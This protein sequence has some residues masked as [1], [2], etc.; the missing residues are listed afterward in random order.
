MGNRHRATRLPAAMFALLWHA[1]SAW[2]ADAAS[3][4]EPIASTTEPAV[5]EAASADAAPGPPPA[6]EQPDPHYGRAAL[7]ELG[8]LA[9]GTGWYWAYRGE[10]ANDWD[11]PDL[12][13][14]VSGEAWRL[15]N[16]GIAMNFLAHALSGS[17][18][19]AVARANELSLWPSAGY[20]F[21]TSFAWE[22]LIEFREK[23]S[24]N[25]VLVTP[26]AGIAIGEY[27]H[28]LALYVNSSTTP[29]G[30]AKNVVR[31]TTGPTVSLHRWLD[32]RS[33]LGPPPAD[34]LG[35]STRIHHDFRFHYGLAQVSSAGLSDFTRH[36]L[37]YQGKLV[38]I[39]GYRTAGTFARTFDDGDQTELEL[40]VGFSEHGS[41]L[42]LFADTLLFGYHA[43]S[44]TGYGDD[45]EGV[46]ATIGASLAYRFMDTHA[47]GV[48]ERI[49]V[50][51]L[52]GPAADVFG[53]YGDFHFELGARV[54]ADFAGVGALAYDSWEQ[55]NPDERAKA[56]LLKKGYYYGLGGSARLRGSAGW[57]RFVLR[58]RA[59]VGLYDS[60]EGLDRTRELV[61]VDTKAR[62][63]IRRVSADFVLSPAPWFSLAAGT[64]RRKQV[65]W[66]EQFRVGREIVEHRVEAALAF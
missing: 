30:T 17:A 4:T 28:K 21:L 46:G 9:L 6:P 66:V 56:I 61:T 29:P 55:A 49:G 34:S 65:S 63:L 11:D 57:G 44:L 14:R 60:I 37:G 12:G 59:E 23:V 16:N 53:N 19:Y 43:Q 51:H 13:A 42:S 52:P 3:T 26:G 1:P 36:E 40:R 25:D 7:T 20:S 15:D 64:S 22:Y 32:D 10:N 33:D 47:S 2:A 54:H 48:P 35:Y 39:P 50:L 38:S 8:L 31:Y 5:H 24:I 62:D 41:G 27:F 18:F 45:L 58:G